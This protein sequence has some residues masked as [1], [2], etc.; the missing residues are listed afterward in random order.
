MNV[1]IEI[2]EGLTLFSTC[3]SMI[4]THEEHQRQTTEQDEGILPVPLLPL[5]LLDIYSGEVKSPKENEECDNS[6]V[7]VAKELVDVSDG[8]GGNESCYE[9]EHTHQEDNCK[10]YLKS[11]LL[12]PKASQSI[13][14]STSSQFMPMSFSTTPAIM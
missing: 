3:S 6:Y 10:R 7:P 12:I 14:S 8:F 4:E 9:C 13:L 11:H 5:D 2:H 1:K